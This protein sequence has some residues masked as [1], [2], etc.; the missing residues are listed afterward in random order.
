[1]NLKN[2]DYLCQYAS[3]IPVKGYQRG[4]IYDVHRKNHFIV[5]LS[6]IDIMKKAK[7]FSFMELSSMFPEE[8]DILLEYYQFLIDNDIC[9][10][11]AKE[12]IQHY[13]PL[14]LEY[15]VPYHITNAI[16]ELNNFDANQAEFIF[17]QLK[18]LLC[19]HIQFF[20]NKTISTEDVHCLL[21]LTKTSSIKTID[22]LMP[23]SNT[24]DDNGLKDIIKE[25]LR[26]L[27]VTFYNSPKSKY[28]RYNNSTI[29]Y[30]AENISVL[31][32]GKINP[33]YFLVNI[34]FFTESH[35]FNNCLNRKLCI[36][37]KGNV[38]NCIAM[39]ESFG[40]IYDD[41]C[42]LKDIIQDNNFQKYWNICKDKVDVC[43]DCEFRYMCSDCRCYLKEPENIYSQPLNCK[44]NPYICKWEGEEG[45][46]SI[47][48]CG[49]Y[50]STGFVPNE[51]KI[52]SLNEQLSVE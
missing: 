44:Y 14:N 31:N 22:I 27:K 41:S 48:E 51:E 19:P 16:I 42:S 47:D 17:Q 10:L 45:C 29:A 23:F 36:D 39:N 12:D 37:S 38:K 6:L 20:F 30:V 24:V 50:T 1:M 52:R 21:S 18:E 13:P 46:I 26:L 33:S 32:C 4:V 2:T 43:K 5:P 9:F 15:D 7:D 28:T 25:N 40:N 49:D 8:K 34:P 35:S 11:C 3:C